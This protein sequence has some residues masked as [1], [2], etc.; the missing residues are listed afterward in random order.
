MNVL[1]IED[2][3]NLRR[4]WRSAL[5]RLGYEVDEVAALAAAQQAI[6]RRRYDIVLLDLYLAQERGLSFISQT[7]SAQPDCD[8]LILAG[9]ALPCESEFFAASPAVRAVL[10]KPVDVE[11]LVFACKN[12]VYRPPG[13]LGVTIG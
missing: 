8:V 9:S 3:P 1:I 5:C 13:R 2:D 11:D 4:L 7:V 10:R 12:T 6:D